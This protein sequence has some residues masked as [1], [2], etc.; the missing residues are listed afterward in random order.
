MIKSVYTHTM[1]LDRGLRLHPMGTLLATDDAAGDEFRIRVRRGGQDVML[2][3]AGVTGYFIR[4]DG[5]TVPITG[6]AEGSEA[7]VTLT[8]SCY[9]LPGRFSLV[10]K[11]AMDGVRHAVFAAEGAVLRSSTDALVDESGVIPSLD[12]LLA[13]IAATEAAAESARTAAASAGEA[14]DHARSVAQTVQDALDSGEL[15]GKGLQILGYYPDADALASAVLSPEAGDAYGV[16]EAEPYDIYVW[17]ALNGAWINNGAIQGPAGPAGPKGDQ[18]EPG[19]NGVFVRNLLDNSDF[20][21]P[22]NQ[23]GQ[24]SYSAAGYTIDRWSIWGANN[25]ASLTVNDGYVSF[26]PGTGGGTLT[27]RLPVGTLDSN[28]VYTVAH[29]TRDGAI[30]ISGNEA[31]SFA[32]EGTCDLVTITSEAQDIVWAALYEGEYTADT[33]PEHVPKEYGAEWLECCRYYYRPSGSSNAAYAGFTASSTAA[34][35]TIPTPVPMRANP[36]VTIGDLASLDFY[37]H[38][39]DFVATAASVMD[40][41]S[42]AVTVLMSG[43][44]GPSGW[45]PFTMRFNTTIELSA[46]L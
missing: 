41:R 6:T 18:G 9:R 10:I 14:A 44:G 23:R 39:G 38:T 12:E 43:T 21:N 45:F 31:I 4:A 17:D 22:V 2:D 27:Q 28:K 24:S 3:G 33:L 8:D 5:V 30:H 1:D 40:R 34:R 7:A 25:D 19:L 16:G 32:Y 29:K 26:S 15:T 46:D 13:Q 20:R 37:T 36:T 42:N 11:A 35:V